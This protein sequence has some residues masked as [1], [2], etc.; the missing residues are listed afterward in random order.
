M[1]FIITKKLEESKRLLIFID[2]KE[3]NKARK[4]ESKQMT[5]NQ[6][7]PEKQSNYAEGEDLEIRIALSKTM[8]GGNK[9][10]ILDTVDNSKE[11]RN[12]YY[13]FVETYIIRSFPL[14]RVLHTHS[15]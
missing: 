13:L 10:N 4:T 15:L 9:F 11:L 2:N 5:S 1:L 8:V 14:T 3:I 12:Y 7:M 6:E